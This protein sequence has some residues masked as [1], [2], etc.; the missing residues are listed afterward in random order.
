MRERYGMPC[1]ISILTIASTIT[2]VFAQS[3][4]PSA[5]PAANAHVVRVQTG[6]SCGMCGGSLFYHTTTTT[7]EPAFLVWQGMYSSNPKKLPNKKTRVAITRQDWTSLL[8]SID[9]TAL[10][11]LPQQ[12]CR[13]CRDLPESW[14]VVEYSDG[15][16]VAVSYGPTNIPKTVA[17][18]KF[19]AVVIPM[20]P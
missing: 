2:S 18:V 14:F 20:G 6:E 19:P 16:K 7:V 17:A 9:V 15:S 5:S 10:R 1:V 8:R 13:S 3:P 12:G 4:T 11:A